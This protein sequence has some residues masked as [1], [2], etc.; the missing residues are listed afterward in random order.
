MGFLVK[1]R[2]TLTA[3]LKS[4]TVDNILREIEE[5]HSQGADAFG[6]QIEML[7]PEERC[8]ENYK[9]IISAMKDKPCYITNYCRGN[10]VDHTDDEL[11]EELISCIDY[12]SNKKLL[13][14]RMDVYDRQPGEVTYSEQ[15]VE[16]QVKLIEK[17]HSL[18]AEVLMSA[19]VLKYI[20]CD[21]V[22]KIAIAQKE[23]GADVAKIVTEANGEEELWDN[24]KTS[25]ALKE[26][27]GIPS[28]FLCNGSHCKRHRILGPVLGSDMYL[29]THNS[30]SE[31]QPT[32][33]KAREQLILTGFFKEEIL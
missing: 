12:G 1:D 2:P 19:H 5:I 26:K 29:V 17:I 4:R 16:K 31:N 21:E 25:V 13:D 23:R 24:L 27:L 7:V 28:L 9:K 8:G 22:L 18:G 3:M 33:K 14:I 11:N 30:R 20:P 32:I 6:F 15:A 10:A